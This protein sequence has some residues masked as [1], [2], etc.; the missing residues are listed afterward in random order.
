MKAYGKTTI[1]RSI[2]IIFL[3][4]FCVKVTENVLA[5]LNFT[6]KEKKL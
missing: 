1:P 6:L 2:H 5:D 3:V 4:E